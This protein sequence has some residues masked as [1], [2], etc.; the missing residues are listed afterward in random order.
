MPVRWDRGFCAE[1][2]CAGPGGVASALRGSKRRVLGTALLTVGI[3][4]TLIM[5]K[6]EVS[7]G[8]R[9]LG[10]EEKGTLPSE[11][12]CFIISRSIILL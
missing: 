3:P 11:H 4:D 6:A 12:I 8:D 7:Y 9:E 2:Q 5:G 1:S 10:V